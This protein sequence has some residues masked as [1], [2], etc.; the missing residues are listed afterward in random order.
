[1]AVGLHSHS[2]QAGEMLKIL[3]M[4]YL[5]DF[6]LN[7]GDYGRRHNAF[8]LLRCTPGGGGGGERK[9]ERERERERGR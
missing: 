4:E 3:K 9:R 6:G 5:S 2:P 7:R 1:M 8:F